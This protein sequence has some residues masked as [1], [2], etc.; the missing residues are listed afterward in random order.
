MA[1][2]NDKQCKFKNSSYSGKGAGGGSASSEIFKNFTTKHL[3]KIFEYKLF[4]IVQSCN[5]IITLQN[6]SHIFYVDGKSS[7]SKTKSY[8]EHILLPMKFQKTWVWTQKR[9]R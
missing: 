2:P 6:D 9:A 1:V 5:H 4:I 8:R 3:E 7:K